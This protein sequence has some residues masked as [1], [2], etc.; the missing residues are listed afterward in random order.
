[1]LFLFN[2]MQISGGVFCNLA[3]VYFSFHDYIAIYFNL[4]FQKG[5]GLY[6][7]CLSLLSINK[8]ITRAKLH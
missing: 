3:Y 2:E 7:S 8:K 6:A 4:L 1:M 5:S